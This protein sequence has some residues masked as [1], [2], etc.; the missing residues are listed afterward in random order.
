MRGFKPRL[1]R[2]RPS[3]RQYASANV[4]PKWPNMVGSHRSRRSIFPPAFQFQSGA[5]EGLLPGVG[6]QGAP[7]VQLILDIA[8]KDGRLARN[9]AT[10]VNLPRVGK[11]EQRYLTHDQV[12]DLAAR[13]RLPNRSAQ[14][15]QP[16]T[17]ANATY[18]LVVLFL[19]Y[20]GVGSARWRRC[21]SSRLDLR[22]PS[23]GR[24]RLGHPGARAGTGVG[25][26]QDPPT[27][28]GSDPAGSSSSSSARARIR[29][30]ARRPGVPGDPAR[31]APL[32]VSTFRQ[33][34]RRGS[35]AIGIPAFTPTSCATPQRASPSRPAPTS[36][37][38]NRCSGTPQPP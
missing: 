31:F 36:R 27:S 15:R 6:P 29:P 11:R 33:V 23:C 13:V 2:I 32:R 18:R 17:R 25:H 7:G 10:G 4:P 38:S 35:T 5:G 1:A 9:V 28:R 16:D 14:A 19:A 24:R 30:R 37:W 8:V 34:V 26:A 20:T 12:D 21:G 22:P 3:D